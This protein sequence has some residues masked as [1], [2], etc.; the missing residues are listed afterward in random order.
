MRIA[1]TGASD[2]E[3]CDIELI[4]CN[5]E[6]SGLVGSIGVRA[7]KKV[8]QSQSNALSADTLAVYGDTGCGRTYGESGFG[9]EKIRRYSTKEG[10]PCSSIVDDKDRRI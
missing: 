7:F 10:R 6:T 1:V 2:S 3:C 5:S 8:D 9:L 4:R